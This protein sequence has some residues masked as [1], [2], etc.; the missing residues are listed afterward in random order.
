[1]AQELE[2]LA[3][4]D[5]STRVPGGAGCTG[6]PTELASPI[7]H[8]LVERHRSLSCAEY[9]LCLDLAL[10]RGWPSWTCRRC[11]QFLVRREVRAA[12]VAHE[13]ALRPLA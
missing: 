7:E 9:D 5:L 4:L 2:L 11:T 10:L 13:A 3:L 1:M 12:E 6:N 8:E